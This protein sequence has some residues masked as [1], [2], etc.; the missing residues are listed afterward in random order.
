MKAYAER[1]SRKTSLKSD[2]ANKS[3]I[4]LNNTTN[5]TTKSSSSNSIARKRSNSGDNLLTSKDTTTSSNSGRISSSN[6]LQKHRST[7]TVSHDDMNNNNDSH[8][9]DDDDDDHLL[10]LEDVSSK[11]HSAKLS[12]T[13][14]EESKEA[15]KSLDTM[16][17][18]Y[19]H[20]H[21]KE[22]LH[23]AGYVVVLSELVALL[24]P[25]VLLGK[26]TEDYV[27]VA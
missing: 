21:P 2:T 16:I 3:D 6:K 24:T 22:Y 23:I 5:T 8:N 4:A 11:N 13:D 20:G 1:N 19:A 12:Q 17:L 18:K 10:V 15:N 9:G 7:T 14:L 25:S 26:R 27:I